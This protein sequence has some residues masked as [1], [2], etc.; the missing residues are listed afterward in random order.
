[1]AVWQLHRVE[2]CRVSRVR[3]WDTVR[4]AGAKVGIF[5]TN[6]VLEYPAYVRCRNA[7]SVTTALVDTLQQQ[8][9][10]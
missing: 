1:M 10:T 9:P 2:W 5:G 4:V 3:G 6:I 8:G 7:D